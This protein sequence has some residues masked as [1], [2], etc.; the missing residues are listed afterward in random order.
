MLFLLSLC[1]VCI[2]RT[3]HIKSEQRNERTMFDCNYVYV[4]SQWTGERE[5]DRENRRERTREK[6]K[7]EK[8]H[9]NNERAMQLLLAQLQ[10]SFFL[11]FSLQI[12]HEQMTK[13]DMLAICSRILLLLLVSIN[14]IRSDD[15]VETVAVNAGEPATFICDLPEKYSNKRVSSQVIYLRLRRLPSSPS[16]CTINKHN[17]PD[18][19]A[20]SLGK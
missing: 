2:A 13:F 20:I 14:G 6:E 8:S 4:L 11:S 1:F 9:L 5:R 15:P 17:K 12:E 18:Y 7:K 16:R 19:V 10:L 3:Y